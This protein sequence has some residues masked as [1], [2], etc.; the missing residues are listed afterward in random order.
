[1]KTK[2]LLPL[3]IASLLL[4][5]PMQGQSKQQWRDSLSVLRNQIDHQ[6]FSLE[7][8]LNKAN[9]HLQLEQ[10][11]YAV[12]ECSLV[13]QHDTH[14]LAAYFYRAYAYRQQR[15]YILAYRDYEYILK[16]AP[17]H[18]EARLCQADLCRVMKRKAEAIDHFNYLVD[19][20]A[21]SASAYVARALYEQ[22]LHLVDAALDD[23]EQA[24]RRAPENIDYAVSHIELLIRVRRY[25]EARLALKALESQGVSRGQLL[26]WYQQLR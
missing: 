6:P 14:Q 24:V 26:K 18:Y 9:V 23:W 10:W 20:H 1:M 25:G 2:K 12:D 21:D 22:E 15:Q 4:P 17:L 3:L 11:S 19:H 16:R 5:L 8:H 7:L 13:I